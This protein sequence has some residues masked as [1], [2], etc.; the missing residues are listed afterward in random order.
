VHWSVHVLLALGPLVV[1]ALIFL[2]LN[3]VLRRTGGYAPGWQFRCSNCNRTRDAGEAGVVRIGA[4]SVG[5]RALG[6]CSGCHQF[7]LIALERKPSAG[8]PAA[9]AVH[10]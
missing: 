4:A 8:L 3:A 6:Y 2:V 5:K 10:A 1:L 9:T 7:R